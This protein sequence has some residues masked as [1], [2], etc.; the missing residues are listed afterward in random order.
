MG[1]GQGDKATKA[2]KAIIAQIKNSFN[3]FDAELD[4]LLYVSLCR[5]H[6]EYAV[7]V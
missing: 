7:P 3:Y 1:Y 5:P 6:L 2:A 4:R